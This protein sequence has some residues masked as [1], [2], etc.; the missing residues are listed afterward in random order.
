MVFHSRAQEGRSSLTGLCVRC[1][2][3]LDALHFTHLK[4]LTRCPESVLKAPLSS[5]NYT[6]CSR[7]C[8]MSAVSSAHVFKGLHRCLT[9]SHPP[10]WTLIVLTKLH[11]WYG[12]YQGL[13][14]LLCFS[15]HLSHS[16]STS[17]WDSP[18]SLNTLWEAS[19]MTWWVCQSS[20]RAQGQEIGPCLDFAEVQQ[21]ARL[22][23]VMMSI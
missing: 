20:K 7:I 6:F 1:I 14:T 22:S 12:I 23:H 5:S 2:F 9:S 15:F 16:S 10:M 11:V 3:C 8:V 13:K 18:W 21:Q 19:W 4:N 17:L